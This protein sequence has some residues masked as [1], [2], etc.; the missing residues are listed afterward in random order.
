MPL[1]TRLTALCQVIARHAP[2]PVRISR[3]DDAP[4]LYIWPW[5]IEEDT[6]VRSTRL[7]GDDPLL[8]APPVI[9][10][11]ILSSTSLDGDTIGA[12]EAAR[13]ALL[14]TPV[15]EA[16]SGRVSVVP[17][18]MTSSELTSLFTAADIPLRLCLAY[19]LR[20]TA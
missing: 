1:F 2:M 10:F 19:T 11:L 15:F 8:R 6:R 7:P 18:T 5:R 14:E 9:H 17:A 12:I 20:S 13:L 16:G 4:G 3:P